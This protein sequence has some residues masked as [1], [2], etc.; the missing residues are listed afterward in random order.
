MEFYDQLAPFYHL[1]FPDWEA[2]MHRQGEA[3]ETIL[4]VRGCS[5]PCLILDAAC[6]IGTQSLALAQRGYQVRASDLSSTAVSR[7]RRESEARGL[8]IE[9]TVCDMR[10]LANH[11]RSTFDVV[12]ACDNALPHLLSEAEIL[13]ALKQMYRC[14]TPG[15][16][17][18]ISVRD[19][20]ALDRGGLQVHPHAAHEIAGTR[21]LLFQVWDWKGEQYETTMY[22]IEEPPA[23]ARRVRTMR[24][25]YYAI[26]IR[27][28]LELMHQAGFIELERRDGEYYQPV[29][30]G[31]RAGTAGG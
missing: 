23:E 8:S 21:Y 28:L 24:C 20:D 13:G 19:Y 15:G 3:L 7:A 18:L 11:H 16:L 31:R 2:S 1:I 29:L 17:C 4:R 26:G 25:R 10:G 6:G 30:L 27:K 22:V 14:T 9:I 5:P 12:L